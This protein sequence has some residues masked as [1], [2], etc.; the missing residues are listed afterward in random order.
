MVSRTNE[1]ALFE[2]AARD[3]A[4]G[5]MGVSIIILSLQIDVTPT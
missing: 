5:A 4:E 1:R 2:W 3:F